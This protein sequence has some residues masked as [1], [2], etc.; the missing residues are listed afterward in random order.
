MNFYSNNYLYNSVGGGVYDERVEI[1]DL[2]CSHY[3]PAR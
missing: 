2:G 3:R 1:D